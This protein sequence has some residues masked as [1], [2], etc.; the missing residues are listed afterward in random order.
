MKLIKIPEN[1]DDISDLSAFKEAITEINKFN[2]NL[3]KFGHKILEKFILTQEGLHE[4]LSEADFKKLKLDG[5]HCD[6]YLFDYKK[7]KA[8]PFDV[9]HRGW[10]MGDISSK[11]HTIKFTDD[12]KI[13]I[14]KQRWETQ[15]ARFGHIPWI[16]Q[17]ATYYVD[18]INNTILEELPKQY[19]NK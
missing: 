17:S 10:I 11:K 3:Q 8:I 14:I 19:K 4:L 12:S 5:Y 7:K 2:K 6:E 18:Y 16:P 13:I 15:S 9:S 1:I